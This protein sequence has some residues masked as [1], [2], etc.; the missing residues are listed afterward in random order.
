[1]KRVLLTLLAVI[2]VFGAL[3]GAGFAGY[4]IGYSQAVTSSADGQAF[5]PFGW[6]NPN[7]MPMHRFERDFG[8]GFDGPPMMMGRGGFNFFSPLRILWNIVV[9]GLVV[10]FAYWLFSKSGWR[11]TRQMN[12]EQETPAAKTEG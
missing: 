3:A 5:G 6:T 1:M 12:K 8:R 9:L 11:I 7:L 10:W 2:V 4:R